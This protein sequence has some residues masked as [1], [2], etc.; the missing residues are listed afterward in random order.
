M[1]LLAVSEGADQT[2]RVQCWIADPEK[3][4]ETAFQVAH[5]SGLVIETDHG[6][7]AGFGPAQIGMGQSQLL[8][9]QTA[10]TNEPKPSLLAQRGLNIETNFPQ[11]RVEQ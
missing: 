11:S 8:F 1:I 4:F 5:E 7:L 10:L 6:K 2:Q 9:L 3:G